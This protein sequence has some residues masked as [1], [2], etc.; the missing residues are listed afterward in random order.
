MRKSDTFYARL[1]AVL[2]LP[3]LLIGAL[4]AAAQEAPGDFVP[5][6]CMFG[7]IDLGLTKIGGESLGFECGYVVVPERHANPDGPTIRI[8][9]AVRRATAPNPHPDPLVLAQGGPGGDAFEIFTLLVPSTDIAANRDI[10]IFNQRG[11]P[12]AEPELS[13][14][15]TAAVLPQT[16]AATEE[17][18]NRLYNEALSA[19]FERLQSEGIDLS[20]YNSLENAADVPLVV[21][22]LGYDEY[23]FY[24]VSYGTLLGLHLMRNH[25]EGL[26]SVILDSVIAPDINF[27]SEVPASENRV[28]DEVFA[29][30]EA[31]PDCSEQYPNLEERFFNLVRQFDDKPVTLQLRDPETG[32]KYETYMDG[33]ALRSVMFQMLYVSRMSAVMPKV[34]ADLERGDTRYIE[35]MWP[36]FVFDQLIAEGMYYSVVCAE[37]A[38]ID[39]AAV[40]VDSLRPEIAATARDEIQSY[41]DNCAR[42]QVDLLPSSVDDPVISDIPTLLLS[43]RFDPVT[44]P[45]FAAAVAAGLPNG[46]ALVDPTASHGVA[47]MTQCANEVVGAFLDDP[48]NPPDGACFDAQEPLKAVPPNAV[49]VP[50]LAGV[51]SLDSGTISAFVLAGILLVIVLSPVLLWPLVFAAR[52]FG[53][54]PPPQRAPKDRRVRWISRIVVLLFGVL[55]LIFAV[56]LIGSIVMVV[57]TDQTLMTA[58][59]LPASAA[60]ILWVP[61]FMLL[62]AILMVVAGVMLWRHPGAGTTLGKVYYSVIVIAALA[63]LGVIGAQGLLLPPL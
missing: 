6:D 36:L 34:V 25:P 60:P 57:A 54:D 49:T 19:C 12:Y 63:L 24:G 17:E 4:P 40:P 23:N 38:D 46:T 30:C 1:V 45:A 18:G 7:G 16:L 47:F 13:C 44:P 33:A 55:G 15:E 32:N 3:L 29:A 26:R 22:A 27:L 9:V 10:I 5:S 48:M 37:D 59:S 53:G 39:P 8:P 2:L 20:A 52:A 21:Q 42:W 31:D 14:P 58:L 41:L 11:T 62:M 43:G 28:L 51:N 50:L 61:V 56:G 35:N